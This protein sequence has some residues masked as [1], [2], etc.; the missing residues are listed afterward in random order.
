[1]TSA[2][3][4]GWST[5]EPTTLTGALR[6]AI[7][8]DRDRPFIDF[9]GVPYTY[10]DVWDGAI[11]LAHGL[12]A[13]GIEKGDTVATVLDNGPEAVLTWFATN[14][15]GAILVPINT[16]NKGSFLRHALDVSRATVAVVTDVY[17]SRVV[18]L[19][20]QL[21]HLEALAIAGTEG[22]DC[23]PRR[24]A[25]RQFN[26]LLADDDSPIEA[27][28]RPSDLSLLIF[29]SGTTGPSKA[30]MLSHNMV[31]Q[32]G[33]QFSDGMRRQPD[34]PMW[35][36][37]PLFHL[38]ASAGVMIASLLLGAECSIARRFSASQFWVEIERTRTRVVSVLGAMT[39]II[40]HMEDTPEMLRCYG[41]LRVAGGAPF[42]LELQRIWKERFGVQH[43]GSAGYGTT[44]IGSAI[45]LPIDN[46]GKPEANGKPTADFEARIF[47]ENDN[48][49]GPNE[50][51]ELVVRPLKPN[52]MFEGY[53]DQPE[54]TVATWRNLWHHT[55]DLGKF[56]EDGY[57]YFVDRK[58]DYLRRRGENISSVEL[59]AAFVEH[60]DVVE[61]AAFAVK[62]EHTED[63]VAIAVVS[64][65]GANLTER[66]LILWSLERVPRFA[67]PRFVAL[68]DEL[69]KN[70]VGRVLKFEL[71]DA[72]VGSM[73]DREAAGI[74][75]PRS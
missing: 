31:A 64:A 51:G 63:E 47:D 18:A 57:F 52:I 19:E 69:P 67:V 39:S 5:G 12:A 9:E 4:H 20:E 42:P 26:T 3:Q 40:A 32:V 29:T 34:E 13:L 72:D 48:E 37:L 38:N 61:V 60:P 65:E 15:L 75:L 25:V 49:L 22:V 45:W 23:Q 1:M 74:S 24:L 53:W 50:V 58:K 71:R 35:T 6:Q 30:C 10:G 33:R 44:E 17:C 66:E 16:A 28:V 43:V 54:A 62:S 14:L 27:N 46:P 8:I 70:A 55:G 73:W 2:Q 56:D 59:E 11:R 68:R 36:S 7:D 21:S 41:Q